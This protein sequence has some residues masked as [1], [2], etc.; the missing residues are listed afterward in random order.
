MTNTSAAEHSSKSESVRALA[1]DDVFSDGLLGCLEFIA[2]NFDRS[3]PPGALLAGLPLADGKLTPRLF[4]RAAARAGLSARIVRRPLENLNTL[5]LPSVLLLD[6]DEA[7]VLVALSDNGDAKV[8][9][10]DTG[11]GLAELSAEQLAERY[12][13]YLIL[14]KPEYKFEL[15]NADAAPEGKNWFW[16]AVTPLW[17]NYL[18]ILIA[19]ALINVLALASPLFIMNVYDRVLP[20]KA[21]ST[22]WVLAIGIGIA[23]TF[24]FILKMQRNALI[25]NAGRRA[26]NILASRLFAHVLNLDLS[27]RPMKTGEFANQLRDFEIVREFFTSNT[28][29]T[30]TDFF[31][32]WLFIYIIYII[33][34]MVALA[35]AIA[36]LVVLI[37]GGLLQIPLHKAVQN[38]QS[39]ATHRH[40]LLIE[41]LNGLETIKTCRAESQF[42][43]KWEQ[44]V[45]QNS[46][47]AEKLRGISAVGMNFTAFAQQFV[48]VGVVIIGVYLF[49]KGDVSP[50][51]IIAS[52]ILAGRAVGPLGQ[53]AGTIGRSQ[54]AFH[55]FGVLNEIMAVPGEGEG[56]ERHIDRSISA[57]S[58]EF[59][60]ITFSY[61]GSEAPALKK[62]SLKIEPGERIGIIGRIGSG[63]TTLGRLISRLYVPE[64]GSLLLDGVDVR[65]YHPSDIRRRVAFVSQ[66][67]ALFH[68]SV[69]DNIILGAPYVSD[70]LV[71]RA[72]DLAGVTDFVKLH[73]QG[74]NMPVGEMGRFLS[75]GQRQSITLARAFLFDPLIVFLDEPSGSMDMASERA[76]IN[77]LK[78]TFRDD[79][80]LIVTTHRTSML[81][82][83]TRLVVL[84]N[85]S[86]VAD[87]P[88]DTVL[89]MLRDKAGVPKADVGKT[90]QVQN[91]VIPQPPSEQPI[92]V[93][94][95]EPL[96]GNS[97]AKQAQNNTSGTPAKKTSKTASQNDNGKASSK[98]PKPKKAEATK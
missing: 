92:R 31:F 29:V 19:A 1:A 2:R 20:N 87:G 13:G 46:K 39:E 79:Q 64:E 74:F 8:I 18:Q 23:I 53:I 96:A 69:R 10:P 3:I 52:V 9:M 28:V 89:K 95:V 90:H 86:V 49:D 80:T 77:R 36:V 26:D 68:G 15:G 75:S 22:L 14:V 6:N 91:I 61:P 82:L 7:V 73:P 48:T 17:P 43:S 65:Q 12:S 98:A 55:S 37:A 63:K 4:P 71:I 66:D 93:A 38:A 5:L 94:E 35:P 40:S 78:G 42:Q 85:G 25:G 47:T 41:A 21:I 83:V 11:H 58:I 67:S 59:E 33:A 44:F 24:D 54:Q 27:K 70:D 97:D 88:R 34:G 51:A 62:F 76:L 16:S 57:G 50:G 84:E 60:N 45:G 32:I 81:A 56:Q 72:A 30:I